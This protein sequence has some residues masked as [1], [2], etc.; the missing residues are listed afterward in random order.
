MAWE[1]F[2]NHRC[3]IYHLVKA[4]RP[5]AYGVRA[6]ESLVPEDAPSERDVPCHFHIKQNDL[7][8]L[9]QHE[10]ETSVE[11][12]LKLSLGIGTDIRRNDIIY[13]HEDGLRYRAG[14]PREAGRGHHIVVTLYREGGAKGAI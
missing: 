1:D 5:G 6:A 14:V 9:V 8:R 13:S 2:L 12:Q 3:D 10:P 11:G 4:G 7:T